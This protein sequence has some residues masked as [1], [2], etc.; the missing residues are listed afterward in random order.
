VPARPQ[1][2]DALPPPLSMSAASQAAAQEMLALYAELPEA[3]SQALAASDDWQFDAF[4]VGACPP[5]CL[6]A[7]LPCLPTCLPWRRA[8]DPGPPGS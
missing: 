6:P 1:Q 7:C 3:L 4:M 2:Q 5:A 8:A